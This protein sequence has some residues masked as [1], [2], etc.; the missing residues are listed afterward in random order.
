MYSK[1]PLRIAFLVWGGLTVEPITSKL[2]DLDNGRMLKKLNVSL[3][4]KP[5]KNATG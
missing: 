2:A 3:K 4:E 5:N 1:P